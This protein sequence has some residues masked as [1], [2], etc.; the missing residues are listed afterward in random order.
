MSAATQADA[1]ITVTVDGKPL[2]TF[3]KRSGGDVD[4]DISKRDTADGPQVYHAKKTVN[5]LTVTRGYDRERDHELLRG[6]EQR[7][8]RASMSVSEQPLDAD[9]NPWGKPKTWDG[10]LKSVNS[11]EVDVT[12]SDPRD[13]DLVMVVKD[14][15]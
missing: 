15:H 7:A 11:G 2:G 8:G 9:G 5:D 10:M 1:L 14:V 4:S 6:L 13:L 12:T 3:D